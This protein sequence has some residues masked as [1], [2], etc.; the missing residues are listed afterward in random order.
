M[1]IHICIYMYIYVCVCVCICIYTYTYICMY[2][3]VYI[4]PLPVSLSQLGPTSTAPPTVASSYASPSPMFR[5]S[6]VLHRRLGS[7]YHHPPPPVY[8][9][10]WCS[11]GV[12][13]CVTC[14]SSDTLSSVPRRRLG[15]GYPP[16]VSSS[17]ASPHPPVSCV[18]LFL[19]CVCVCEL[20]LFLPSQLGPTPMVRLG[21]PPQQYHHHMHH[22]PC[23]YA[24]QK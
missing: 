22:P 1:H 23:T 21:L 20:Y 6:L 24:V 12:F 10:L 8:R 3:Y 18:V 17:Y 19:L 9:V 7:G 11:C 13:V 2:K 16:T 4:H 15:S 14:F 5:L